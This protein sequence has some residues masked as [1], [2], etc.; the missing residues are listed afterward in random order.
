MVYTISDTVT[1]TPEGENIVLLKAY[2]RAPRGTYNILDYIH[3][4]GGSVNVLDLQTDVGLNTQIPNSNLQ[5]L[6][7][8]ELVIVT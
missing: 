7:R 6:E 2:D 1:I 8:E 5:K 4:M 3:R